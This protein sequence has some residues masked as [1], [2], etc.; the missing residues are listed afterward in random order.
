MIEK[1]IPPI[2]L[3]PR[4]IS[5]KGVDIGRPNKIKTEVEL[6]SRTTAVRSVVLGESA[7]QAIEGYIVI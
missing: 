7:V 3:S 1:K 4:L 5:R 6:D 2:A